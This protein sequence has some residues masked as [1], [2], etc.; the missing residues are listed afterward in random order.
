MKPH[1]L[2]TVNLVSYFQTFLDIFKIRD[3]KQEKIWL[4]Q[5]VKCVKS[6]VNV[7]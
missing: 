7:V 1:G 6:I 4:T 2:K 5:A 3:F